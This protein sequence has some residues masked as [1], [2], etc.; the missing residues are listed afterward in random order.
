MAVE[1]G[2]IFNQDAYYRRFLKENF[3]GKDAHL[4]WKKY[5]GYVRVCLY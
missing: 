3:F 1:R 4:A 5:R 2:A